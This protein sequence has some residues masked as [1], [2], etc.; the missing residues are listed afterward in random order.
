MYLTSIKI[1]RALEWFLQS[2]YNY[3]LIYASGASRLD[4]EISQE[5]LKYRQLIDA[6]TGHLVCF[7]YFIENEDRQDSFIRPNHS[8]SVEDFMIY[9]INSEAVQRMTRSGLY[10]GVGL[11]TTYETTGELCKFFDIK[12]CELPAFILINKNKDNKDI[13]SLTRQFSIFSIES[14]EDLHSLLEPIKIINDYQSDINSVNKKLDEARD[15]PDSNNV[16]QYIEIL[17][18]NIENLKKE[19]NDELFQQKNQIIRGIQIILQNYDIDTS[20]EEM[21]MDSLRAA[22]KKAGI[23]KEFMTQHNAIISKYNSIDKK[24]IKWEKDKKDELERLMRIL[25]DQKDLLVLSKDKDKKIYQLT[26]EKDRINHHYTK[27]LERVLLVDDASELLTAIN[28]QSSALPLILQRLIKTS[29]DSNGRSTSNG[30]TIKC[31]IAGSKALQNERDALRAIIS[32]MHNRWKNKKISILSYTYEDFDQSFVIGGRQ[33]EYNQFIEK[34]AD[35]VLIIINGKI[36]GITLEEY[37]VAM[38]AF[39]KNGKPK[40]IALAKQDAIDNSE[41]IMIKEE[42]NSAHQYWTEYKDIEHLKSQFNKILNNDLIELL[43]N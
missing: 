17:S 15:I 21:S 24:I 26:Q 19:N 13:L 16:Q 4:Y 42:I 1:N 31:F 14:T 22:L 28:E 29:V 36:G 35:W 5:V 23:I 7:L 12:Q 27:Q 43:P 6:Q 18:N 3:L 41:T 32:I 30:K 38:N 10:Y 40:I 11:K 9:H 25:K 2:K 33:K 20:L 8:E 34:D 37:Q 39:M